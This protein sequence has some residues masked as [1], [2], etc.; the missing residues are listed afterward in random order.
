MNVGKV[1]TCRARSRRP[2]T[3]IVT[4]AIAEAGLPINKDATLKIRPRIFLEGNFFV[5]LEP[6]HARRARDCRDGGTI[7]ITQT[8]TRCSSTR[9]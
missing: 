4:M 6:G 7:P 5:D 8:A 1:K 3:A 2:T 9:C